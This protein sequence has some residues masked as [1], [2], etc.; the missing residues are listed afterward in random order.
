ML[1]EIQYN[2][3]CSTMYGVFVGI[4]FI[5]TNG[6]V[7]LWIKFSIVDPMKRLS[8]NNNVSF[9]LTGSTVSPKSHRKD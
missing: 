8:N 6:G 2:N 9:W 1:C 5:E 4:I 3:I 7:L